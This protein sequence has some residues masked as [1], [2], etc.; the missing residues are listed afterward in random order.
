MNADFQHEVDINSPLDNRTAH[1]CD[2]ELVEWAIGGMFIADPI[3]FLVKN[4]RGI[5]RRSVAAAER[6]PA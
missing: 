1:Y 4:L 3:A 5:T 6:V 2:V